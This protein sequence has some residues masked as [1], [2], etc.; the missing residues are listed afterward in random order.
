MLRV[1][2]GFQTLQNNKSTRPAAS[3]VSR[4]WKP[5][6]TLTLVSEILRKNWQF[7]SLGNKDFKLDYSVQNNS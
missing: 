4:V 5:D 1:S 6:E 2:L 3:N 7:I